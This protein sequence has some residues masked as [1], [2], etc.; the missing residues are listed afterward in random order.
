[1]SAT[2]QGAKTR[3]TTGAT[4]RA[5]VASGGKGPVGRRDGRWDG[6]PDHDAHRRADPRR[7]RA[8]ASP[9]LAPTPAFLR[10]LYVDEDLPMA[11]L[12]RRFGVGSKRLRVW[13]GEAGIPIRSRR[14]TGRRRQLLPPAAAELRRM[15]EQEGMSSPAIAR[16]LGISSH[17]ARR[18]LTEAGIQLRSSPLKGRKRGGQ[19]PVARP[20]ATDIAR[21]YVEQGRSLN[22][23]ATELGATVHL[24]RTWMD[25]DGI[26][27]RPAGG[28]RGRPRQ[29]PPRRKPP[30]ADE[31]LWR[32]RAQEGWTVRELAEHFSVHASTVL[33]WLAD[34]GIPR[35]RGRG[36]LS[37]MSVADLVERYRTG[38]MTAAELA[39]QTGLAYERVVLELREAGVMDRRRRP[40][41]VTAAQ[42]ARIQELYLVQHRTLDGIAEVVGVSV[43]LVRRQLRADGIAITPRGGAVRGDR[44]EAPVEE[45]QRLYVD[46][47]HTAAE[48][49]EV[50]EVLGGVVLRTGHDH[51][52]PIRP[53][54]RP[55][56][57]A[58]VRLIEALY[59]DD[60]VL[61]AMVRHGVPQR[62]PIGG[63]AV[64]FPVPVPLTPA[65]LADLYTTAGCS[66]CQ[67]ELL[68]GQARALVEDRMRQWRIPLRP[69]GQRSPA[70]TR[71][72]R[73][74][75]L[76]WL[77]Q[78]VAL[79][80]RTH[81]TAA[82][83]GE[84]GCAQETARRWLVE[85]GVR[86]P[87]RGR[88]RSGPS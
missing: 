78:A 11:A 4:G 14:E 87:G 45:V 70:L 8:D 44:L 7:S 36:A 72:R 71:Y 79:Y 27:R 85:A 66:T 28:S 5:T 21:M 75:R 3:P 18:W 82:V 41:H 20:P 73:A 33:R 86:V 84:L 38:T 9:P 15:Y 32:L 56:I 52:L 76:A 24:V 54:G 29:P 69:S 13:L 50:L 48:T 12:C 65:L 1:M 49:G 88:W 58:E 57:P 23:V 39:R 43:H 26:P 77:E 35:R 16:R 37:G 74:R 19:T 42:A 67:I 6:D 53:S 51:G 68:T 2:N 34:A 62:P 64:R 22:D 25:E 46:A 60:E 10:Q 30:P 40:Q 61:E 17:T 47:G 83:A 31:E 59:A 80:E 81:S 63:I 55:I